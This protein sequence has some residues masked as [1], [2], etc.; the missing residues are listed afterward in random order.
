MAQ[1]VQVILV[2]DVDG[3]SADETVSFALDGVHYEIDLSTRRASELRASMEPWVGHARRVGTRSGRTQRNPR[4]SGD[5]AA[6]RAWAK[7]RGLPVSERGRVS[8]D[9][10]QKYAARSL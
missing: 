7:S 10:R 6:I 9:I 1:K 4:G 8:A 3:G 2:D 5:V